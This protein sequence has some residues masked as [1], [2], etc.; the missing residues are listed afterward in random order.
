[1]IPGSYIF[2][3]NFQQSK[4]TTWNKMNHL[5]FKGILKFRNVPRVGGG[6]GE[7]QGEGCNKIQNSNA[8]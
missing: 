3:R 8:Y 5:T 1:M 4:F 7:L 2:P 6:G